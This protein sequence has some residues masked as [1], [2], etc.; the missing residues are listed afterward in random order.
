MKIYLR[1]LAMIGLNMLILLVLLAVAFLGLRFQQGALYRICKRDVANLQA[2]AQIDRLALDI[3]CRVYKVSNISVAGGDKAAIQKELAIVDEE[4]FKLETKVN[5]LSNAFQVVWAGERSKPTEAASRQAPGD[6]SVDAAAQI[7]DA[8]QAIVKNVA[9]YKAGVKNAL[10]V[11]KDG[12]AD[13]AAMIMLGSETHFNQLTVE[14]GRLVGLVRVGLDQSFDDATKAHSFTVRFFIAAIVVGL[15]VLLLTSLHNARSIARPLRIA[16]SSL[17]SGAVQ[18]TTVA[19]LVSSSSQTLAEGASQQAAYME[20]T[21]ASLE[22]LSSM[23]KRNSENA[24]QT[25]EMSKKA[26]QAAERGVCDM[27]TMASAMG[28]I[29]SS[30]D[31]V[32]KIIKTID[33]IAFQ[34]NI[35]ALNAAVEAAR[36]GEAGMGF[37]VVAEEVR[38]LAQRSAQAARETAGKIENAISRTGQGMEISGKVALTLNEI[39]MHTRKVDDLAAEVVRASQEQTLGIGQINSAVAQLDKVTQ[40]NAANA[41]EISASAIELADQAEIMKTSVTELLKVVDGNSRSLRANAV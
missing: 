2:A 33:E 19:D 18:T 25:T 21:S 4:F 20:Q 1:L 3:N 5:L 17:S 8:T 6:L 12:D 38:S 24:Q 28:A 37:A 32:S 30:S 31:D 16:A 15:A 14:L 10:S 40:S 35:L 7:K 9:A 34:T 23:T 13:T 39:V 26:R 36:A 29:K 11:V 27:Q 41:E 22:E